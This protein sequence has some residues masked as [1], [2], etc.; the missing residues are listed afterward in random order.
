MLVEL[1]REAIISFV[2]LSGTSMGWQLWRNVHKMMLTFFFSPNRYIFSSH[3][4]LLRRNMP[5]CLKN[6]IP[7]QWSFE[8]EVEFVPENSKWRTHPQTLLIPK[9][10]GAGS[11]HIRQWSGERLLVLPSYHVSRVGQCSPVQHPIPLGGL[12]L[13]Y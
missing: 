1:T 6:Y 12:T 3:M 4:S 5:K 7:I 9:V 10:L 13:M 11:K 2:L 8:E